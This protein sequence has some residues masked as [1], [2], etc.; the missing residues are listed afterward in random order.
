MSYTKYSYDL[1]KLI[2]IIS[3]PQDIKVIAPAVVLIIVVAIAGAYALN[4]KSSS[5]TVDDK[6]KSQ[7][8][9]E[10]KD[11]VVS[12]P[13]YDQ[14]LNNISD[15]ANAEDAEAETGI[16]SAVQAETGADD[17]IIN[18]TGNENYEPKF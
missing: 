3:M 14:I 9:T 5:Q 16:E 8:T 2:E 13:S 10:T 11:M 1:K 12:T 7:L 15:D 6:V 4:K 18:A 17:S